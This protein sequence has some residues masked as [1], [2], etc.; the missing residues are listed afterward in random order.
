MRR[1]LASSL[2]A[3]TLAGGATL[4][5]APSARAVP[6][7]DFGLQLGRSFNV[8]TSAPE[9]FDQGGFRFEASAL[10]PW[11]ERFRFGVTVYGT[12]LGN[13]IE[14]VVI[15]DQVTHELRDYGSV[16]KGHA[17]AW[18]AGWRVDAMGPSIGPVGRGFASM[19]YGYV[20]LT[21]D[22]IGEP[23]GGSSGLA[24]SVSLGIERK[25]TQHQTLALIGGGTWLTNDFTRHY[26]S[27][28]LE[29]RW[30]SH[31]P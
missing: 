12:D 8:D 28:G 17:D 27:A 20:R 29:W 18:G 9:G 19:S 7:P 24:G 30:R 26:G 10:W 21:A 16:D 13:L 1:G 6:W 23:V 25:L 31:A 15:E 22:Q 11:E 14:D 2:L 3:L 4:G 5:V